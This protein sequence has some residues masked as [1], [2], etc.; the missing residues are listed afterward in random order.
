MIQIRVAVASALLLWST[1]FLTERNATKFFSL[2]I[3]A[4]LF[5]Y[6]AAI[7]LPFWFINPN[8]S[9]KRLYLLMIPAAYMLAIMGYSF[10]H[11]VGAIPVEQIQTLW[12]MY[13]KRMEF[14]GGTEINIFNSMHL[15]RCA[16]SMFIMFNIDKISKYVPTAV[17]WAKMYIIS[18]VAFLLL[19]DIPVL[20]FR[21]SEL[22][23][24]VEILLIPSI[25][26]VPK[27]RQLGRYMIIGFAAVCIFVNV[28]YNQYIV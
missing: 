22:L 4:I 7:I 27:Y 2:S 5:H 9:H 14:D 18:L 26:L 23:Q 6:S 12:T 20:S 8:K 11:L 24:I 1:K 21:I 25:V 10:G 17:V 19:S 15:I 28:F 16:M 3:L 13:E